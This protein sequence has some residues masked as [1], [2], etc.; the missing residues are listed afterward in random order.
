MNHL[1]V[2]TRDYTYRGFKEFRK[3][4]KHISEETRIFYAGRTEGERIDALQLLD[5]H[6]EDFSMACR[7]M[8]DLMTCNS[9]KRAKRIFEHLLSIRITCEQ[10]QIKAAQKR[11]DERGKKHETA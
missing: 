2:I 5:K 8:Q 3:I 10:A 1:S 4:A 7:W 9:E 11:A 6:G